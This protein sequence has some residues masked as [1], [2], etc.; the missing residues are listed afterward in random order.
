MNPKSSFSTQ[1]AFKQ[2]HSP[3]LHECNRWLESNIRSAK[4]LDLIRGIPAAILLV[5]GAGLVGCDRLK[6]PSHHDSAASTQIDASISHAADDS[7]YPLLITVSISPEA[8]VK[9]AAEDVA[10]VLQ[11]G[12]WKS[13]SVDID[14]AAGITAPLAIESDQLSDGAHD[15]SRDH[16]LQM[17]LVPNGPLSGSRSET[18]TLRLKS[19]DAGVRTAVLNF[20]AGQGTQD[21]GF[22]SDVLVTFKVQPE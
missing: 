17:E 5:F 8:R 3:A 12:K 14:N 20:N 22:R 2:F 15:R 7:H 16:W 4:Y 10:M 9:A 18:R 21:L 1:N 6:T 19:R 11:Q 13:F